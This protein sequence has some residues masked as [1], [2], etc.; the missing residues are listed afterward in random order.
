MAALG[1]STVLTAE[2]DSEPD[3]TRP[4]VHMRV[5]QWRGV[6]TELEELHRFLIPGPA[7]SPQRVRDRM[8]SE[9]GAQPLSLGET[10]GHKPSDSQTLRPEIRLASHELAKALWSGEREKK[11]ADLSAK[12]RITS[13]P[14]KTATCTV[15]TK[16]AT[17]AS[18]RTEAGIT[19]KS[20]AESIPLTKKAVTNP[21]TKWTVRPSTS[22]RAIQPNALKETSAQRITAITKVK[23]EAMQEA[24]AE[25]ASPAEDFAAAASAAGVGDADFDLYCTRLHPIKQL[26]LTT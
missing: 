1:A 21:P 26:I 9:A 7:Q 12:A 18:G 16:T 14:A 6:H 5:E 10:S 4:R 13:T 17:G 3:I 25:V 20:P 8:F 19:F 24:T 11:A 15:A 22:Y 23:V 2:S